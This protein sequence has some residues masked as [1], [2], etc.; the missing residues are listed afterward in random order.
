VNAGISAL[1]G[2]LSHENGNESQQENQHSASD[3]QHDGHQR[4]DGFH[5][6]LVS[7]GCV[8]VVRHDGFLDLSVNMIS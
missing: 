6:I 1:P 7:D 4:H 3:R 8:L 2:V 5:D